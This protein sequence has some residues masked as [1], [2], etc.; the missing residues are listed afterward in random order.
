MTA[1]IVRGVDGVGLEKNSRDL[2]GL[3]ERRVP[4]TEGDATT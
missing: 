3:L 2:S 1:T 4:F